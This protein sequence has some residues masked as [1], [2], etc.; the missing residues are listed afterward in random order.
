[1]ATVKIN[2][3]TDEQ[4]KLAAEKLFDN[5]GLTMTSALNVFLKRAILERRIPFEVGEFPNAETRAAFEEVKEMEA[6][7]EDYKGYRSIEELRAALDV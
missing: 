4:T 7:P 1:M 2:F 6:H 3:S 5:L